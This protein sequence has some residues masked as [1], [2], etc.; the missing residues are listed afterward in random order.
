MDQ[1]PHRFVALQPG[2]PAP[3]FRQRSTSHPSYSFDTVGGRYVVMLFIGSASDDQGSRA[4]EAVLNNRALFDDDRA[5]FFGITIDPSDESA[6]RVR[7]QLPGI[8]YFWDFNGAVS[9]LYGGVPIDA[10]AGSTNVPI[11]RFWLILDPTLHVMNV[12]PFAS[13]GNHQPVFDYVRGLPEPGRFARIEINAPVIVL[14]N[15]FEPELC[16][17]LIGF[18]QANGGEASGYMEEVDGKT[19]MQQDSFRK[20]RKD[21]LVKDQETVT[22]IQRRVQNRIA[23]EIL[24]VHFFNAS[25]MERYIVSCYSAEDGGH[26]FAH[27]DNTTKGTAHR[28]FAVS[29]NL[30]EEFD[31]GELSFPEYGPKSIKIPVGAAVVFSCSL[32]HAVSKVTR[33]KRYAFL[34]FLYDEAAAEIRM[35]NNKFLDDSLG[36]YEG[37]VAK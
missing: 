9:R 5:C 25:R 28:R 18:Y 22:L 16:A 15:V 6:G 7:Q 13:D 10:K 31:G 27:R 14:P 20:V 4:L 8:R 24:K 36:K 26:F 11:R 29:I 23:P 1:T 21:Y 33:G 30:N 17:R 32:L 3:W 19:V 37:R 34:P 2:D 35:A 12:F